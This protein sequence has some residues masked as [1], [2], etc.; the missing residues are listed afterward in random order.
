MK[1]IFKIN[2]H[3]QK[4][5]ILEKLP[6]KD[7]KFNLKYIKSQSLLKYDYVTMIVDVIFKKK[8]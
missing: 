6:R 1:K 2:D 4:K 8:F 7:A 3:D 5:L